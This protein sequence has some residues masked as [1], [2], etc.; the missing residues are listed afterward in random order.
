MILQGETEGEGKQAARRMES[1]THTTRRQHS[2]PPTPADKTC[3]AYEFDF[4]TLSLIDEPAGVGARGAGALAVTLTD[5]S[6]DRDNHR[7]YEQHFITVT[8]GQNS[9]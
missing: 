9:I 6:E 1:N 4:L 5:R 2:L 8:F 7:R 3:T